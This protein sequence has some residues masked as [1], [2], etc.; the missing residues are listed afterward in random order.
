ME[1]RPGMAR[2]LLELEAR[3]ARL[4][5]TDEGADIGGTGFR[6]GGIT[7]LQYRAVDH[8]VNGAYLRTSFTIG[9]GDTWRTATFMMFAGTT[10][11]LK[12]RVDHATRTAHHDRWTRAVELIEHHAG[13]RL[14]TDAVAAVHGGG[15]VEMSGLRLDNAGIH[16][17]GLFRRTISWPQY[18]GVRREPVYLHLLATATATA[19]AKPKSRI[20]V[21]NGAWNVAILP[22]VLQ[23]LHTLA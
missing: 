5:L 3:N 23:V 14:A 6:W 7:R 4:T 19:G 2:L 21:P 17:V 9:L 22:R 10:G 12:T 1:R 18:A 15:T 8:H 13:T 20:Q 11:P 16:K